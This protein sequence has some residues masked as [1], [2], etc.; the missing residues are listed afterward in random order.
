[1][2]RAHDGSRACG[3]GDWCFAV[4]RVGQKRR[5]QRSGRTSP[6]NSVTAEAA[7]VSPRPTWRE[8]ATGSLP[9]LTDGIRVAPWMT[10]RGHRGLARGRAAPRVDCQKAQGPTDRRVRAIAQPE[11]AEPAVEIDLGTNGPVDDNDRCQEV[12]GGRYGTVA[13]ARGGGRRCYLATG[14]R[15]QFP[16]D[17]R[18]RSAVSSGLSAGLGFPDAGCH[19]RCHPGCSNRATPRNSPRGRRYRGE[20]ARAGCGK[21]SPGFSGGTL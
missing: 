1:L 2:H 17:S 12:D 9:P 13:C 19:Q 7:A 14:T 5:R 11:H 6:A 21:R 15:G 8:A 4:I 3:T 18:L 10:E 20:K 16:T